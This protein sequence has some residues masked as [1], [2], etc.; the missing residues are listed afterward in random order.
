[1]EALLLE[2]GVPIKFC[3]VER[4]LEIVPKPDYRTL[5]LQEGDSIEVVTLV[6]GG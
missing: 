6:G 2:A 5:K 1:V 3:A 4:N